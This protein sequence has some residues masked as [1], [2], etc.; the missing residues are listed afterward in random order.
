[1]TQRNREDQQFRIEG[2]DSLHLPVLR[3][4]LK[5]AK[6]LLLKIATRE[7]E[8]T[9]TACDSVSIRIASYSCTVSVPCTALY[10][11]LS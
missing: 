4:A 8:R 10:D 6:P 7:T 3:P 11:V 9:Q 1:M 5:R 2:S